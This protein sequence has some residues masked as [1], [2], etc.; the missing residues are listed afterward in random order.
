MSISR[1]LTVVAGVAGSTMLLIGSVFA[2]RAEPS[3]TLVSD[4]QLSGPG[5]GIS[6]TIPAGWHQIAD[7]SNPQILQMVY[8]NTCSQGLTCATAMARLFSAQ[9]ASAQ[10]VAQAAEQA[11]AGQPGIQGATVTSQGPTQIAGKS[12]YQ[13]R[14]IYSHATGKFQAGAAAIETGPAAAGMVPTSL[15][16]VTVSDLAGAP[17]AS[18]IDEIIGSAQ[19]AAQ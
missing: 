6:V 5:V 8:P 11:I 7:Q 10:A 13:L 3:S 16:L 18:T 17:P 9:A 12:G 2:T 14:F 4:S 1:R 15:V 19:P